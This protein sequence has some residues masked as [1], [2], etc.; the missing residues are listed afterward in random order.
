MLVQSFLNQKLKW[1]AFF[2][3]CNFWRYFCLTLSYIII[4]SVNYFPTVLN[5]YMP[6]AVFFH[7]HMNYSLLSAMLKKHK[8]CR[9]TK[10]KVCICFGN[11]VSM[12]MTENTWSATEWYNS[13]CPI[14]YYKQ[15][16][17]E[18]LYIDH[19]CHIISEVISSISR[20]G[21]IL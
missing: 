15:R 19:L 20:I 16:K 5:V 17:L 6:L 10:F 1:S 21:S 13:L 18:L 9:I 3:R 11:S 8:Y 12:C 2:P 7:E 4:L 14:F